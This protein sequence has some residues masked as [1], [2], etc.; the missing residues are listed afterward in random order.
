MKRKIAVSRKDEDKNSFQ[1]YKGYCNV[2][3]KKKATKS[4]DVKEAGIR[5]KNSEAAETQHK[6]SNIIKCV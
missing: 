6:V 5:R 3:R 4:T 1:A 2:N